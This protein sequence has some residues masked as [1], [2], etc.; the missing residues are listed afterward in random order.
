LNGTAQAGSVTA[1]VYRVD[2]AAPAGRGPAVSWLYY[3]NPAGNIP[4]R[5]EVT[6]MGKTMMRI[7]VENFKFGEP[8]ADKFV[9]RVECPAKPACPAGKK[10][11]P[12]RCNALPFQPHGPPPAHVVPKDVIDIHEDA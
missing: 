9:N 4:L 3:L 1:N 11:R 2:V 12:C 6:R 7:D 8:T 5:M 10:C